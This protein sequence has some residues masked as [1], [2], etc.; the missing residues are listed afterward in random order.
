MMHR[1]FSYMRVAG[2][3]LPANFSSAQATLLSPVDR[4]KTSAVS[5][6]E[7]FD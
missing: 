7:G 4:D 5:V 6:W 1:L 3:L 2:S